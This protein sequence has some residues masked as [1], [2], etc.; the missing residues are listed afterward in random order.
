MTI[1][2]G[3]ARYASAVM[4]MSGRP[5]GSA[6]R[7]RA[8]GR[9]R[10]AVIVVIGLAAVARLPWDSHAQQHAIMLAIGLAALAALA[11]ESQARSLARLAAWDQRQNL[12]HPRAA[13]ADS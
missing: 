11:R 6:R 5:N 4:Q 13:K 7:L 1:N 2:I 8:A 10:R 9:R 12:R 3:F